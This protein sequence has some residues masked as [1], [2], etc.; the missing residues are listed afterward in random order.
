M[1]DVPQNTSAEINKKLVFCGTVAFCGTYT[2]IVLSFYCG[3]SNVLLVLF[4][5]ALFAL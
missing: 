4:C 1:V 5:V 3:P 2:C